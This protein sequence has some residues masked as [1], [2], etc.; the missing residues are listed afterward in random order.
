M[1]NVG[2]PTI[3]INVGTAVDFEK[4]NYSP[5]RESYKKHSHTIIFNLQ[6]RYYFNILFTSFNFDL[7][8]KVN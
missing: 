1:F 8:F 2:A 6:S 3:I 7:R 4:K 5:A